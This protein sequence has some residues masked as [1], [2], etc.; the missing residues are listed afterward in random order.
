MARKYKANEFETYRKR[1]LLA[2]DIWNLTELNLAP[3]RIELACSNKTLSFKQIE[4]SRNKELVKRYFQYLLSAT[5]LSGNT[6]IQALSSIKTFLQFFDFRDVSDITTKDIQGYEE[7]L[8][9]KEYAPSTFN[10]KLI[11]PRDFFVFLRSRHYT[12]E[13]IFQDVQLNKTISKSINN[14][15][16]ISEVE[17]LKILKIVHLFPLNLKCMFSIQFCTGIR[18][19][20]VCKLKKGCLN[21]DELG[22]WIRLDVHKMRKERI[23]R[24]PEELAKII[25]D[26]QQG[27]NP[28]SEYL[29]PSVTDPLKPFVTRTYNRQ[30]NKY[31]KMCGI[32]NDSK[33]NLFRSHDLRHH[34][35]TRLLDNGVNLPI[36]QGQLH[37]E[38]I[39]MTAAYLQYS[40]EKKTE[41]Y[42]KKWL[43]SQGEEVSPGIYMLDKQESQF[44]L[45]KKSLFAQALPNGIC[46]RPIELGECPNAN[47]CLECSSF[48]TSMD[49]IKIHES[50]LETAR[51]VVQYGKRLGSPEIIQSNEKIVGILE[52]II[53][54]L[55]S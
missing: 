33:Q 13:N 34:F 31:L 8:N 53:A 10:I 36:V 44:E 12:K 7:H 20:D 17:L 35:A 24:V 41:V 11:Y 51:K 52:K 5:Q 32:V 26:V 15:I 39:E 37:H 14:K 47:A 21:K 43:N 1:I 46:L 9:E 3:E 38:S 45:I 23:S 2:E 25:I 54:R 29:F 50:Q 16:I 18:V 6:L 55:N 22:Y 40:D 4:G 30:V 27:A 48:I 42:R 28:A 19:N 49:F